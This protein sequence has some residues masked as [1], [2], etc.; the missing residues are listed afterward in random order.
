MK[1]YKFIGKLS[2]FL[3]T[4]LSAYRASAQTYRLRSLEGVEVSVR[5]NNEPVNFNK[6]NKLNKQQGR[7]YLSVVSGKDTVFVY[8]AW[9]PGTGKVLNQQ[10]LQ[11]DYPVRGGTNVGLGSTLVL[12]VAKGKLCQ[13]FKLPT[14]HQTDLYNPDYHKLYQIRLRLVGTTPQTYQFYLT[15]HNEIRSESEPATNHNITTQAVL[16]FDAQRHLFHNGLKR[17]PSPFAILDDKTERVIKWKVTEPLPVIE[18]D[19]SVQYFIQGAWYGAA[20][21]NI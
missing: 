11:I 18:W 8:D 5:V 2:M 17:P 13:A 12:C 4:T 21:T 16:K 7:C 15:T 19:N 3:L 10:F 9:A 14:Y 1:R 6:L 20:R